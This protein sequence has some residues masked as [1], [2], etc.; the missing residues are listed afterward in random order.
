M[1]Y[2]FH[3][4]AITN[5][6]E[7]VTICDNQESN[8]QF[9]V[10]T[11]PEPIVPDRKI[12]LPADHHQLQQLRPSTSSNLWKNTSNSA[13]TVVEIVEPICKSLTWTCW[14]HQHQHTQN[15]ELSNFQRSAPCISLCRSP[16]YL[17]GWGPWIFD[18][19]AQILFTR[20]QKRTLRVG[21]GRAGLWADR[22]EFWE[23]DPYFHKARRRVG[24][25]NGAVS[26][27]SKEP[28]ISSTP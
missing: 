24:I 26:S 22:T 21:K 20:C 27:C 25:K 12:Q 23:S 6:P 1:I 9:S 14:H 5:P 19:D 10:V 28:S 16:I 18:E 2:F 11:K 15:N 13:L 3:S 17:V 7:T 4:P 8:L